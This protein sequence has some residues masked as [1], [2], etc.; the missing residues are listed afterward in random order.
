MMQVVGGS[1]FALAYGSA[2]VGALLFPGPDVEPE[3]EMMA[4]YLL[5]PV[6]GPFIASG[7]PDAPLAVTIPNGIS[8]LGG[9]VTLTW[10]VLGGVLD[11]EPA[12][13]PAE[14]DMAITVVPLSLDGTLPGIGVA[15]RF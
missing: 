5:I 7:Q 13:A 6:V 12:G 2:F 11:D 15:G 4:S 14:D 8:Q 1:V 9:V 10:G 3:Q